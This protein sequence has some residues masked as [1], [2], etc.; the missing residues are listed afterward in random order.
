MPTSNPKH[1]FAVNRVKYIKAKQ[2]NNKLGGKMKPTYLTPN[3]NNI[4]SKTF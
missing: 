3:Y 2:V 4:Y 1:H